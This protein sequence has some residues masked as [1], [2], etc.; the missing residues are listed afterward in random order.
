MHHITRASR[1]RPTQARMALRCAPVAIGLTALATRVPRRG[2]L[3]IVNAVRMRGRPAQHWWRAFHPGPRGPRHCQ[4]PPASINSQVRNTSH[5]CQTNGRLASASS[6]PRSIIRSF[7][8]KG[9]HG[10]Q[11]TAQAA[12]PGFPPRSL[13]GGSPWYN[14]QPRSAREMVGCEGGARG[15]A[16]FS[17]GLISSQAAMLGR[18]S[19]RQSVCGAARLPQRHSARGWCTP[20]TPCFVCGRMLIRCPLRP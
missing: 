14:S 15:C 10:L 5:G 9:P 19:Y 13:P 20:I 12:R 1:G 11:M 4:W 8:S 18:P 7:S 2:T 6:S 3:A 17:P 16:P